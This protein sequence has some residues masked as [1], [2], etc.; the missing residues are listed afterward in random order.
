MKRLGKV[1]AIIA[2]VLS[3]SV[4]ND[5]VAQTAQNKNGFLVHLSSGDSQ[6]KI[7]KALQIAENMNK[8][9][10][11]VLLYFDTDATYLTLEETEDFIFLEQSYKTLLDRLITSEVDVRVCKGNL[12]KGLGKTEKDLISGVKLGEPDM[13]FTFT[14][15]KV[16]SL[17][18]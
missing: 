6:F 10:N 14:E 13:F 4:F 3:A 7:I 8:N 1:I 16:I 9:G 12:M 2:M 18:Y 15:G 5:L 17:D 11:A